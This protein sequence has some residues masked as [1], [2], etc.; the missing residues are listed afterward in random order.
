MLFL[1]PFAFAGIALSAQALR[2][3]HQA[4]WRDAI[5]TGIGALT[6]GGVGFGGLIGLRVGYRRLKEAESLK[7]TH[8]NEPWLW[9]ADWAAGRIEDS[10]RTDLLGAWTF[11]VFWNLVS[12]PTA[13]FALDA[14]LRHNKPAGFIALLFPLVGVWL[15]VRASLIT[16]RRHKYGISRLELSTTPGAIG[17]T[18]AATVSAPGSLKPPGGFQVRLACVRRVR[19][20][21][22]KS[23]SI[24]ETVLW[25]DELKVEGQQNRDYQGMRTV[26]PVAF[27][28]PGTVEPS[29]STDANNRVV[30]RLEVGGSVPGVDYAANFEIPV[31]RRN[32]TVSSNS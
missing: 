2:L 12:C 19:T 6:F 22:G 28:L 13:Y 16:L 1:L 20:R 18:L 5:L 25:Q 14:A 27:K 31:F 29:D 32:A 15:L 7:A 3:A 24:R 30:W 21:S 17:G 9:R 10:S 26:I 8:P 23:N 4:N 11:A